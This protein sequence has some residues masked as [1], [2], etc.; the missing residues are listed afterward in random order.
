MEGLREAM[1]SD[2]ERAKREWICEVINE[3]VSE[4]LV[5]EGER[6]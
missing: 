6:I 4:N 5:S 1:N 2:R 3:C